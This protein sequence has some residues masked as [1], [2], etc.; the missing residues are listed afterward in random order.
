MGRCRRSLERV[1]GTPG[2]GCLA[3]LVACCETLENAMEG[4][5]IAPP[6][7]LDIAATSSIRNRSR[8]RSL[9]QAPFRLV[10]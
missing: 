4:A 7:S 8:S 2:G 9:W 6:I 3:L 10:C 5:S 1:A